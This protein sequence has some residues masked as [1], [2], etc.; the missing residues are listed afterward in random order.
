MNLSIARASD[1]EPD[2]TGQW[3]AHLIDGPTLGPF[4]RRSEALTAE[5]GWLI[6][7]VLNISRPD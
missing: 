5:Q 4:S 2:A 3:F 1:V 6:D 7:H